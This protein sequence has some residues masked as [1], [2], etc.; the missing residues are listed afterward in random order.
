MPRPKSPI[1]PSHTQ[2]PAPI[3]AAPTP[4]DSG[5]MLL[6]DSLPPSSGE[7][8]VC[9]VLGGGGRKPFRAIAWYSE[10]G[11]QSTYRLIITHWRELP[12]MPEMDM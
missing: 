10:Y 7:Y 6:T 1:P 9:A 5:W 12:P 4:P 8:L 2:L 3:P 11:W